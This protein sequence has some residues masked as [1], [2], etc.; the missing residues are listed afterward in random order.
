MRLF[1]KKD[2]PQK[3]YKVVVT[4]EALVFAKN[5]IHAGNML[6]DFQNDVYKLTVKDIGNKPFQVH[7]A[8]KK[9]R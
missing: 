5:K 8:G 6:V 1:K 4:Y 2:K 9:V 7:F 3:L